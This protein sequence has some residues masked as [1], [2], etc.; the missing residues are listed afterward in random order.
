[1]NKELLLMKVA[2]AEI[3]TTSL[4]ELMGLSRNG[5]YKKLESVGVW[6]QKDMNNLQMILNL[7]DKEVME[8]WFDNKGE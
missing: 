3:T 6:T 2:E 7:S 8:I 4:A 1:M 5:W